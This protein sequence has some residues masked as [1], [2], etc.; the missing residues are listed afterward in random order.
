MI[1][2]IMIESNSLA[3]KVTVN[4]SL[5]EKLY[6]TL[7]NNFF[8]HKINAA[9]KIQINAFISAKETLLSV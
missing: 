7:N 5:L 9:K 8:F 4:K 3:K 2:G 6:W 1:D